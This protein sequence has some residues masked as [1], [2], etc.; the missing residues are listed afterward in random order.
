MKFL[1]ILILLAIPLGLWLFIENFPSGYYLDQTA[2]P[3]K[4]YVSF[5]SDLA[6]PFGLYFVLCLFEKWIPWLKSW[7]AK[8]LLVFLLPTSIEIGQFIYQKLEL[9]RILSMYGG[10][11]DPLDF[12]AFATGGLLAALLERKVF[13]KHFKFWEQDTHQTGLQLKEA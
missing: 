8:T 5:F 7:Q 1:K 11:F 2:L 10:A 6:M 9:T 12:V 3:Y 13:A 4:L